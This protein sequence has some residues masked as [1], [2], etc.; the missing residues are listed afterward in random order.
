MKFKKNLLLSILLSS[1][2]ANNVPAEIN[3]FLNGCSLKKAKEEV[4]TIDYRYESH[5]FDGE[6]EVGS[7]SLRVL[8]DRKENDFYKYQME[9]YTGNSIL[10]YDGYHVIKQEIFTYPLE[11]RYLVDTYQYQYLSDPSSVIKT[12]YASVSYYKENSNELIYSIFSS[13]TEGVSNSGGLYYGDFF[14][15]IRSYYPYMK[16]EEDILVYT[17]ENYPYKSQT[18]QGYIN[19]VIRMDSLGMILSLDQNAKNVTTGMST[20]LSLK[21]DYNGKI[22]RIEHP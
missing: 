10:N 18:E 2:A 8:Y 5:S 13:K 7:S 21:A 3:R 6:K 19:E 16:I 11:D 12:K 20:T 9:E 1:C 22:D 14:S 4:R 15:D 17:L